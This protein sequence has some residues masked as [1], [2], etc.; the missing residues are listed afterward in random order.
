MATDYGV[1]MPSPHPASHVAFPLRAHLALSFRARIKEFGCNYKKNTCLAACNR[2]D[3]GIHLKYHGF[4][5]LS[6]N[7]LSIGYPVILWIYQNEMISSLSFY[8]I[9]TK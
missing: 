7:L 1:R 8:F 6:L 4:F 5:I 2:I 9:S 3:Y